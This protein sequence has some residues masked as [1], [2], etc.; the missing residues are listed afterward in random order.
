MSLKTYQ[1]SST[2]RATDVQ[3]T[4]CRG[5]SDYKQIVSA[6]TS[7]RQSFPGERV[8]VVCKTS[9]R[10]REVAE[11]LGRE[12]LMESENVKLLFHWDEAKGKTFERREAIMEG[13][14]IVT[15]FNNELFEGEISSGLCA[16]IFDATPSQHILHIFA[17]KVL[18]LHKTGG[19]VYFCKELADSRKY[20]DYIAYLLEMNE[21][22]VTG[23]PPGNY[24]KFSVVTA[25]FLRDF[26]SN[27]TLKKHTF[28]F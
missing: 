24:N 13:T 22:D 6:V 7:C 19:I 26:T 28:K 14:V 11:F 25:D 20:M 9:K 18:H 1:R 17:D 5:S 27:G 23:V 10:A 21:K 8:L 15:W 16:V 3:F 4:K 12:P 2:T